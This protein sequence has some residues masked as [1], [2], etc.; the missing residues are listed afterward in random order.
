MTMKGEE[1][2]EC[3][4]RSQVAAVHAPMQT[5]MG[6]GLS[7][8]ISC[9]KPSSQMKTQYD[10]ECAQLHLKIVKEYSTERDLLDE[11]LAEAQHQCVFA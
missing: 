4:A 8:F 7:I 3:Y 11:S 10:A 6:C 1:A 9:Y 2:A 5:M